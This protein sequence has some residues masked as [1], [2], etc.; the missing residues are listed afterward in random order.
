MESKGELRLELM[1][2]IVDWNDYYPVT[3]T[4]TEDKL[5]DFAK[6]MSCKDSLNRFEAIAEIE[7]NRRYNVHPLKD[8]GDGDYIAVF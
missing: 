2:Y 3:E 6:K 4:V 5:I 7:K 8:V 1:F